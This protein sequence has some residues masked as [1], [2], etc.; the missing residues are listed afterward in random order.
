M[1]PTAEEMLKQLVDWH[2]RV[3]KEDDE[4]KAKYEANQKIAKYAFIGLLIFAAL[5]FGLI[6]GYQLGYTH[7]KD[8]AIQVAGQWLRVFL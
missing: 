7:A 6:I 2:E 4:N 8:I 1:E 5:G 3:R